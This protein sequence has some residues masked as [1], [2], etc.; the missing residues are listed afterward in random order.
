M[1][2]TIQIDVD[3]A[4]SVFVLRG[5]IASA[6]KNTR[7]LFALKRLR[8]RT[9]GEKLLIPFNPNAT[10]STLREIQSVLERFSNAVDFSEATRNEFA[11]YD[12]EQKMFRE[13][14]EN[15]RNIRNDR[16]KENPVLVELFA[17]F[18]Q[19]IKE[20]LSRNLYPMQLLSAFHLA[21]SQYACNFAVPGAGKQP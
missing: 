16:F 13:F 4:Q 11:S 17:H 15:A 1:T 3:V 20:S 14:S 19:T 7:L 6:L 18:Q 10:I 2:Q 9:E 12:R 5:D 8:F 21:Y